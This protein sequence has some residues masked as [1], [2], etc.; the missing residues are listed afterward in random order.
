MN[1]ERNLSTKFV[2][3]SLLIAVLLF[4]SINIIN[5]TFANDSV[6]W[7]DISE[8]Q[9]R[10]DMTSRVIIPEQYR[11]L[12]ADVSLLQLELA[13]APLEQMG[14]RSENG[15][16]M[17]LP[18]PNGEN[19]RFLVVESPIMEPQL[20]AKFP[21]IKTYAG[22]GID[23]PTATVRLDW[24]PHGFHGMIISAEGTI[25]IDPYSKNN[26]T[27]YISYYK[28]DFVTNQFINEQP[29]LDPDNV[30]EKIA[31][32]VNL[33]QGSITSGADLVTYRLAVAATG[34]YTA[35][36]GGSVSDGQ[37]AIVTA[38][39]RINAIYRREVAV[40]M[41]LVANNDSVV[42]TN[43]NTDPYSNN[44]GF[45][46]LD[47][48]QAT[49]DSIIGS[50][51]YDVGH[52][53]STG[54]GGVAGLGVICSGRK[55]EGV[56]GLGS[57]TGD[58]FYVDYV[59]HELGHQFG[60]THTFNSEEG[61]CGGSNRSGSTAY[62]PGGATTIMGYAGICGSDNIQSNSDAYF[63]TT[64]FDQMRTHVT[65]GS[66]STCGTVTSTGNT[67]PV[68]DA[69]AGGFTIPVDTPFML[70][71]SG[72]DADSDA[73]TYHWEQYDLGPAGSPNSPS[74]NAPLFRSF[75]ASSLPSRTF[76]QLSDL[77]NNTSTLGEYLPDYSRSLQFRLTV[78]DNRFVGG[79]VDHDSI[80]FDVTN[81][82][83]PFLVTSPNGADNWTVGVNPT[84]T[85]DVANTDLAPVSCANVNMLL[86]V[87]GGLTY[88]ITLVS[89][90][91]NDGT[92]SITI[93]EN[94][95][96][97][98]ARLKIECS[99]NI[100]FDISNADYTIST[101]NIKPPTTVVVTG[102]TTG[103]GF[104]NYTFTADTT[105]ADV[106]LPVTYDWAVTDQSGTTNI[107]LQSNTAS[108]IWTTTGT[109]TIVVTATNSAGAISS[110]TFDVEIG[111]GILYL[112]LVIRNTP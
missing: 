67:P 18:L 31:Q 94:L 51:N 17:T 107:G 24:T 12:E 20:A 75:T 30:A 103:Y 83:G 10:V 92:E 111:G 76:P 33:A 105:P 63:H 97:T 104:V 29:P 74:G 2:L 47:Q 11:T 50:G 99:D 84:V 49:L 85:W 66:G 46:M 64:N 98:T 36:H 69:G 68:A 82:A 95:S 100:F 88:P 9:L 65:A 7:N 45:A 34:E 90:T 14:V 72:S 102:T 1:K 19:G 22:Q 25:F 4:F 71:G 43:S 106:I 108:F 52:V 96:L 73:L 44:D 112:P 86:S 93:S 55:G 48:N 3:F 42:F 87:D 15:S 8:A 89:N 70:T 78:R 110:T 101:T 37:A 79:G 54:G 61:A 32:Q 81:T 80:S 62:E 60:A 91:P 59:A 57:P 6:V 39:N 13:K 41:V 35:F 16:V 56:T 23:D 53:F 5:Q 109:K 21:E 40:Q 27:H 77:L 28:E 58:P 38:I 26:I